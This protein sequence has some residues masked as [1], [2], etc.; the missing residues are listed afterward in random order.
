MSA[1]SNTS[2]GDLPPVSDVVFFSPTAA[3]F[4]I[5]VAVAVDPVKA[6]LSTKGCWTSAEPASR[7]RPLTMLTIPGGKPTSLTSFAKTRIDKGVC[8]AGF[9]TTVL[10]Q[11]R[12]GPSFQQAIERG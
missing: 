8:S 2:N 10:P 6:T 5:C 11:A 12:A 3:I 9:S 7:S 1:S 4:M